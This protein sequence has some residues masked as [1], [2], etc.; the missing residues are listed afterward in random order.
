VYDDELQDDD[1][2]EKYYCH[3]AVNS[4]RGL[5]YEFEWEEHRKAALSGDGEVEGDVWDVLVDNDMERRRKGKEK[6]A[7][8]KA[9]GPTHQK[10]KIKKE[11]NEEDHSEPEEFT[12]SEDGGSEDEY[13]SQ[14]SD[15]EDD[16]AGPSDSDSPADEDSDVS[17]DV[18]GEP[19]TPSKKR[20]RPT[21]ART[22]SKSP[23][24]STRTPSKRTATTTTPTTTPRKPTK[25]RQPVAP[26]PQS[27]KSIATRKQKQKQKSL[28]VRPPPP[29]TSHLQL[30][31]MP[32]DP[33]LRAMHVLH[34][35]AR[36][37]V[38]PCR[39]EEYA[40]CL[41]AVEE[42]VEEG[43]GGCVCKFHSLF[44]PIFRDFVDC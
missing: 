19:R 17:E 42:L 31:N 26:T 1:G 23:S 10:K 12:E 5:F 38:L 37:D 15:E 36:P 3:S 40:R 35:G 14:S 22:Y 7:N 29:L 39:E 8:I 9:K 34:V 11:D 33:W 27:R 6:Q 18:L 2:T 13:A 41:R 30:E 25:R 16:E 44:I 24:K 32:T 28:R 21:V 43:S 4:Q 20:K